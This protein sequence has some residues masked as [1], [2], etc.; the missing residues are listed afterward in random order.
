VSRPVGFVD[1]EQHRPSSVG[2]KPDTRGRQRNAIRVEE[3]RHEVDRLRGDVARWLRDRTDH[4]TLRQYKTQL[5]AV[6]DVLGRVLTRVR[7]DVAS[8]PTTD[9]VG[10]VYERCRA[11][12]RRTVL[13]RRFWTFFRDKFDQRD[14]PELAPVLAAA[15]EVVWSCYAESFAALGAQP[16]SAPLPYVEPQLTPRALARSTPPP[17]LASDA[18]D[19][20]L[21]DTLKL[22]P[23]PVI[24]IPSI[25]EARP[26]WLVLLAHETG[27]QVQADVADGGLRGAFADLLERAASAAPGS[28]Q[29]WRDWSREIFADAVSVLAVGGAAPR[30]MAEL[31]TSDDAGLLRPL[32]AYPP[33]IVRQ[34][35]MEGLAAGMAAPIARG[36]DAARAAAAKQQAEAVASEARA[37]V[38]AAVLAPDDERLRAAALAQLGVVPAVVAALAVERLAGVATLPTLCGWQAGNAARIGTWS[39]DFRGP[40]EPFPEA[41]LA[42]ARLA[43]GGAYEAWLDIAE[44][45]DDPRAKALTTLKTRVLAVVPRCREPSVR[46]AP[47]AAT[48][49]LETIAGS[50]A[51]QLFPAAGLEEPEP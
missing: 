51:E 34:A 11:D 38:E 47:A 16:P 45:P 26:W 50:I 3:S 7:D 32:S 42:S 29:T 44:L 10:S 43:I 36:D 19:E 40:G 39:T 2:S 23:L 12:D 22:L 37:V 14:V 4:D 6:D 41:T 13:V 31:E 28:S 48:W 1:G 30:A 24:G 5:N 33:P 9:P 8:I 21:R 35:L 27:H 17:E 20:L 25:C 49:Q 15:D 18:R 46:A